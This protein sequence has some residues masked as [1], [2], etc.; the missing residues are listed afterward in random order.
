MP[1]LSSSFSFLSAFHFTL[2][3]PFLASFSNTEWYHTYHVF[4]FQVLVQHDMYPQTK[5]WKSMLMSYQW[6]FL[7]SVSS[8]IVAAAARQQQVVGNG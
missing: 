2:L 4:C 6:H 1:L 5:R 8:L 7:E 3:L